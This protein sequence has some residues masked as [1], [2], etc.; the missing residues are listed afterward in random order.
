M[1]LRIELE[2][3]VSIMEAHVHEINEYEELNIEDANG[4]VL[5]EDIYSIINNPPFDRSPLDGYALRAEDT[6]GASRENPIVLKVVDEVFAGGYSEKTLKKGE[7]IRIMTGAKM[8]KGSD[9]VIRQENTDEGMDNVEIYEELK[10]HDNYI[11]EGE[12]IKKDSLIIKKGE[13][14]TYVHIGI[15]ASMGYSK[16]KVK[17]KLKVAL[18]VTGDEVSIPGMPLPQGKIYDSNMNLFAARLKELGMELT[19]CEIIGDDYKAVGDTIKEAMNV[20][21]IVITTGGVSVGKKD[22]LHE[23]LPY[24]GAEILYWKV[25]LQPGTPA[26]FSMYD[27]KPILS[28][29]G[30]PFASL[31]TFEILGRP[32]LSKMSGNS[33]M[34][35]RRTIGIMESEFNKKSKKRRFIRAYYNNGKVKLLD[36]KHSSGVL[37]SMI[38]CNALID[39]KPGTE[40]LE[41]G[42]IV[43][44]ILI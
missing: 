15:L 37:S 17:K 42:N 16:V 22:I 21:D 33:K 24:I 13:V 31:A 7:A 26:I 4:R 41:I 30:N 12:D 14:L 10:V 28:L 36:K 25:N 18:L 39:I 8:P 27:N 29:S 44:I 3:A 1:K 35:I 43:D 2:E 6:I 19:K 9:C 11:F 34:N 20:S 5:Y 23:S 40:K 32:V 38:G